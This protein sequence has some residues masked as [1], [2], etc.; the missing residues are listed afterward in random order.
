MFVITLRWR[1]HFATPIHLTF[2]CFINISR[3]DNHW[4]PG[5]ELY[6]AAPNE[7]RNHVIPT[8]TNPN[9]INLCKNDSNR[10][11]AAAV[12]FPC[13]YACNGVINRPIIYGIHK[14]GERETDS[15]AVSAIV[16]NAGDLGG[17]MLVVGSRW[18]THTHTH[19]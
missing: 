17:V 10:R 16:L 9:I 13:N 6:V 19:V 7:E 18:Y 11:G 5:Y 15:M 1:T 4:G 3:N 12:F 14:R 2:Y 8:H